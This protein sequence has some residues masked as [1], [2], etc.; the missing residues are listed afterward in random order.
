MIALSVRRRIIK[1]LRRKLFGECL[2]A[3][4]NL[5]VLRFKG[6]SAIIKFSPDDPSGR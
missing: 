6:C 3:V 5:H 4:G 1:I 2:E